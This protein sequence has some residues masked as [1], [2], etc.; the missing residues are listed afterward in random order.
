MLRRRR[1]RPTD[2]GVEANGGDRTSSAPTLQLP[3]QD[4]LLRSGSSAP[5]PE[6]MTPSM[7]VELS[8]VVEILAAMDEPSKAQINWSGRSGHGFVRARVSY[9]GRGVKGWRWPLAATM[10]SI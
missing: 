7:A 8:V 2:V 3:G 10:T 6:A 4:S 1:R 9:L 5:N